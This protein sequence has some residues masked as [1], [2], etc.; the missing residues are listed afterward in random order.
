MAP[1]LIYNLIHF[2]PLFLPCPACPVFTGEVNFSQ[3][4]RQTPQNR[5]LRV[6]QYNDPSWNIPIY[7]QTYPKIIDYPPIPSIHYHLP[8]LCLAHPKGIENHIFWKFCK[9]YTNRKT[10]TPQKYPYS[11]ERSILPPICPICMRLKTRLHIHFFWPLTWLCILPSCL[12]QHKIVLFLFFW[13]FSWLW[14]I[15]R[16][17]FF[18][19]VLH[20]LHWC[21]FSWLILFS[22]I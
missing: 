4:P 13:S 2:I 9:D 17:L 7:P 15:P 10:Q 16:R 18:Q 20:F 22:L 3:Y 6:N 11:L 21:S 1:L 12:R 14:I 5:F 8:S 19:K